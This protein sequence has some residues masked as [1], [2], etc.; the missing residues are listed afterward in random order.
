M[1]VLDR[2]YNNLVEARKKVS[3][4]GLP[5]ILLSYLEGE[6]W[7]MAVAKGFTESRDMG[8]LSRRLAL[9]RAK[10][11]KK[12]PAPVSQFVAQ[13]IMGNARKF[14]EGEIA[15][16][17]SGIRDVDKRL[18]STALP[19]R[20]LLEELVVSICAKKKRRAGGRR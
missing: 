8:E 14:S 1:T 11:G 10:A 17:L 4:A 3:M 20:I 9:R 2:M 6:F 16:A 12:P 5:L 15:A 18:K 19:S 13:K 7:S